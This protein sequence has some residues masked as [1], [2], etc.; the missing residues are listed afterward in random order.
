MYVDDMCTAIVAQRCR[1][2]SDGRLM[3][4][5]SLHGACHRSAVNHVTLSRDPFLTLSTSGRTARN[6]DDFLNDE[7]EKLRYLIGTVR[8]LA[9][10]EKERIYHAACMC[11][12][13]LVHLQRNKYATGMGMNLAIRNRK[14]IRRHS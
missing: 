6:K 5:L 2:T 13:G 10:I 4:C 12:F 1:E 11:Y 3:N 9:E 14:T 7:D 8:T